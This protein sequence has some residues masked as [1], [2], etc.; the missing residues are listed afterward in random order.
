MTGAVEVV[1]GVSSIPALHLLQRASA[2]GSQTALA[3]SR[4]DLPGVS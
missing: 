4:I 2:C 3:Y 1:E